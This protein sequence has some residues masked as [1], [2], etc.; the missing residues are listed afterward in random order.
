MSGPREPLQR[1]LGVGRAQYKGAI[2]W[3]PEMSIIPRGSFRFQVGAYRYQ[4]WDGEWWEDDGSELRR[5]KVRRNLLLTP[6]PESDSI[7]SSV[8]G[9][10]DG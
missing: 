6:A 8:Q 10:H 7:S 1:I 2:W 4:D 3:T 5:C 9:D